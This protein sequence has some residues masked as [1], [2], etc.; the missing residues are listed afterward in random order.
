ML[1]NHAC[2]TTDELSLFS[3][4]VLH[5]IH[6]SCGWL[7][8][9]IFWY[10]CVHWSMVTR[11]GHHQCCTLVHHPWWELD[12]TPFISI[13]VWWHRTVTLFLT[14]VSIKAHLSL[15]C[16]H[17]NNFYLKQTIKTE[18][19]TQSTGYWFDYLNCTKV[20]MLLLPVLYCTRVT[21]LYNCTQL[22]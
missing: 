22:I 7:W 6:I 20:L 18:N 8:S 4:S 19:T 13:L 1:H 11:S 5:L 2:M 12:N 9:D 21:W 14:T 3:V 10:S 15:T 16:F 17:R